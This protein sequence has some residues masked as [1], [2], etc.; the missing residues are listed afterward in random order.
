VV[1][2][3]DG[4]SEEEG[5]LSPAMTAFDPAAYLARVGVVPNEGDRFDL[6][7]AAAV[8]MAGVARSIRRGYAVVVDYG[9]QA[10][11]LY[12][13][14]RLRGTVRAHRRHAVTDDPFGAPGRE[15]LTAHVDFTL[16][17]E[18]AGREGMA[19]AGFTTQAAFLASLGLGDLLVRLGED[20]GTTPAAY[21]AAQAAILRLVDPAGWAASGCWSWRRTPRSS[22]RCAPSGSGCETWRREDEETWTR[23]HGRTDGARAAAGVLRRLLDSSSRGDCC[24]GRTDRDL[25]VSLRRG[26]G[27]VGSAPRLSGARFVARARLLPPD[28]GPSEGIWG[29]L[30]EVSADRAGSHPD[31]VRSVVADD[32]RA[33]DAWAEEGPGGDPAAVLAAARYWELPPAYVHALPG[34]SD[35]GDGA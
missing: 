29:I 6:S 5:L 16:L 2:R 34:W 10:A 27:P 35:P 12:R 13:D 9:Y 14:H 1:R 20:P 17:A 30:L 7:P 8:W 11:T 15:D 32:G 28:D 18:A 26:H 24:G 22:H 19:P 3:G 33:Y 21:Y 4:F 31:A 25:P 23:L